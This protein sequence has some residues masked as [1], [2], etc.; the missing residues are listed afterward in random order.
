MWKGWGGS[1][2]N[3]PPFPSPSLSFLAFICSF[4][5]IVSSIQT[6]RDHRLKLLEGCRERQSRPRDPGAF[7]SGHLTARVAALIPS[8]ILLPSPVSASEE[9]Y[10]RM[11]AAPPPNAALLRR[12][13]R[14]SRRLEVSQLSAR[15]AI[16]A[17]SPEQVSD[18]SSHDQLSHQVL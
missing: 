1:N 14:L 9:S 6:L 5:A 10:Q 8:P 3:S 4:P 16:R 13:R 11:A 12:I 2:S 15:A 17:L 7:G 18:S